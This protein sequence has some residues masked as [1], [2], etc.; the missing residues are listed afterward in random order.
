MKKPFIPFA[1]IALLFL[2][3]ASCKTET[4]TPPAPFCRVTKIEALPLYGNVHY[5][6][7]DPQGRLARIKYAYGNYADST[8]QT[9]AIQY[10]AEGRII[11][12]AGESGHRFGTQPTYYCIGTCP[13]YSTFTYGAD[14]RV[15]QATIYDGI[16]NTIER[17]EKYEYDAAGRVTKVLFSS[18]VYF[19]NVYNAAGN[20]DAVYILNAL[21]EDVLWLKFPE[22][23]DKNNVYRSRPDIQFIHFFKGALTA[24]NQNNPLKEERYLSS[25]SVESLWE[26]TS[27]THE[28]DQS[29][30]PAKTRLSNSRLGDSRTLLYE[31]DCQP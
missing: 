7:F 12:I 23:D 21:G 6:E 13:T 4:T 16:N 9:D 24:Y 3:V 18:G 1:F 26:T 19:R 14:G 11:R 17:T 10:D 31:Y 29:N 27:F 2:F 22:T 20:L 25:G 30:Y 8:L 5:Y 28:Y 15:A